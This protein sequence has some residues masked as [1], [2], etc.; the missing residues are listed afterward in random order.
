MIYLYLFV[1]LFVFFQKGEQNKRFYREGLMTEIDQKR[2]NLIPMRMQWYQKEAKMI[3]MRT[4]YENFF[5]RMLM[6]TIKIYSLFY[7]K[8]VNYE[9]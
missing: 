4:I 6:K 1:I 9:N 3:T 2:S 7:I 8:F 5:G